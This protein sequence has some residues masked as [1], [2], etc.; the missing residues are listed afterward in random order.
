MFPRIDTG[1]GTLRFV[2]AV[3]RLAGLAQALDAADARILDV[4]TGVA[5]LAIELARAFPGSKWSG[6]TSCSGARPGRPAGRGGLPGRAN[7]AAPAG[8]CSTSTRTPGYQLAWVPSPFL[9][10]V[11][12]AA[13]PRL[14]TALRPSGWLI[15]GTNPAAADPLRRVVDRWVAARNGGSALDAR[16][17]PPFSP[18]G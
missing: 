11:T 15:V 2:S 6:S 5:A 14:V 12:L 10:E 1:L 16:Q 8:T 7:H 9:P 4:G 18:P 13:L 3:P 17:L